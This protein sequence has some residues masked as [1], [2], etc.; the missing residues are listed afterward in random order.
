MY[1]GHIVSLR[2]PDF[3]RPIL[4][5]SRLRI[6]EPGLHRWTRFRMNAPVA[7]S[8]PSGSV[9]SKVST[10]GEVAVPQP[11]AAPRS[12]WH[13][14]PPLD[15]PNY[16]IPTTSNDLCLFKGGIWQATVPCQDQPQPHHW[17]RWIL[18]PE[19]FAL[20]LNS[21]MRGDLSCLR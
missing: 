10:R 4:L 11:I 7:R 8:S 9:S 14:M 1:R 20:Y 3:M 2:V 21:P 16:Y 13:D 15:P 17:T 18:V 19:T 5:Q 6:F 12:G